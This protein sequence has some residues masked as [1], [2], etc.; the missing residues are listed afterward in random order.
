MCRH[1]RPNRDRR[2]RLSRHRPGADA[3][4]HIAGPE[5]AQTIQLADNVSEFLEQADLTDER[6]EIAYQNAE[7]LMRI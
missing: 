7:K 5:V 4:S 2:R 6:N 1:R 3:G